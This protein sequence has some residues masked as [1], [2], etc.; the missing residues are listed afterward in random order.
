MIVQM[1]GWDKMAIRPVEMQGVVQRNQD[2][3]GYKANQ[4]NKVAVDQAN[5]YGNH[6][7]ELQEKQE[8]VIKKDNADYNQMNY[9]AKEKGRNEY[10]GNNKHKRKHREEEEDG[11]VVVKKKATFD[12]KI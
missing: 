11:K 4:D 10:Q 3:A 12:V 1:K 5:F 6:I 9:D 8:N 2:V 7:K